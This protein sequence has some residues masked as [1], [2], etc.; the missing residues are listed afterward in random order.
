MTDDRGGNPISYHVQSTATR[1]RRGFPYFSHHESVS[2]LWAQKWRHLC[3]LGVY[4]FSEGAVEDFDPIFAELTRISNDDPAILHRP[5][6][7]ARPFL[8]VAERLVAKAEEAATNGEVARARELYLRA[9]TVYRI[10]RFPINRSPLSQHAWEAGKAAYERG[11]ELLDPPNV[12]VE[13]PF[14]HVDTDAGDVDVPI[15]AYLRLPTGT[16]PDGGWPV[17]LYVCGLDGYR[18]DQ[19]PLVEAH[20]QHGCAVVTFEIPGT[21]DCPAAPTDPTSPDRLMSSVI[22]WVIARR[23]AYAFDQSRI[24]IRGVSTGGYYAYR[25]A[26][27]HADRLLA[28]VAHGGG[29]HHMFDPVWIGAQNQMEYPFALADALAYKF[30]YRQPDPSEAVARYAADAHR[31]SLVDAGIAGSPSCK[32]L[33]INGMEDS[34]FPIEDSLIAATSGENK[35]LVILGNREHMGEPHAEDIIHNW[36]DD[37]IA[38]G[39]KASPAT[40][41]C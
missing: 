2:A 19:T 3:T 31:F 16:N 34:I 15:Q 7:Y 6:D 24:L 35:D 36:I 37:A 1:K 5:D 18:T 26:H 12:S 32:L 17:L 8:P 21:G 41:T 33:V 13:I 14:A 29:C 28:V 40:L 23:Q 22:D 10:A 4:P 30:G 20:L 11:A 38:L 25:A 27:T 9:A 39:R